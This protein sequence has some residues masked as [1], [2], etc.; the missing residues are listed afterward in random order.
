LVIRVKMRDTNWKIVL[1][2]FIII[3]VAYA[4]LFLWRSDPLVLVLAT[5]IAVAAVIWAI[6]EVDILDTLLLNRLVI[7]VLGISVWLC[8]KAYEMTKGH[9]TSLGYAEGNRPRDGQRS[10]VEL[11]AV[12]PYLFGARWSQTTR[13]CI[14]DEVDSLYLPV[15]LSRAES[16]LT[17]GGRLRFCTGCGQALRDGVRFCEKCGAK[18]WGRASESEASSEKERLC[19]NCGCAT[20]GNSKTC[21]W[22]EADL[23]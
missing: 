23:K 20:A 4:V 12:L 1:L 18:V 11:E 8:A 13:S 14:T 7:V 21:R 15:L 5:V 17:T 22:C 6:S 10:L 16:T 3:V 2:G 19:G 9:K